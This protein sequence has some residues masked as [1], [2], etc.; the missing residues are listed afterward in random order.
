MS[1][2]RFANRGQSRRLQV[3]PTKLVVRDRTIQYNL[4]ISPDLADPIGSHIAEG[5]WPLSSALLWLLTCIAPGDTVLDLGAHY[6]SFAVPAACLAARVTAIEGSAVNATILRSARQRNGLRNLEV[7]EAVVAGRSGPTEFV[8]LGPYG[9]VATAD[10]ES[11]PDY[12]KVTVEAVR[13]DDLPGG[14]F[15]WAKVDI[16]GLETSVIRGSP[17]TFRSLRGMAIES[18]GYMLHRHGSDPAGLVKAIEQAGMTVYEVYPGILRPLFHPVLQPETIID[19]IAVRGDPIL[20]EGWVLSHGRGRKE[21]LRMLDSESRH[22]IQEHRTYATRTRQGLGWRL[23]RGMR[24]GIT[25][26]GEAD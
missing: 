19:Y 20:P 9:T 3:V 17:R 5:R 11:S 6:G 21:L 16:E 24:W 10:M 4:V 8:N 26:R 25:E 23:R 2:D 15:T 7:I 1:D 18:N 22:H 13:V 14:P 12:P